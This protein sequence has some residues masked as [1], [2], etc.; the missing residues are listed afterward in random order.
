MFKKQE[1]NILKILAANTK[2]FTEQMKVVNEKV[3]DIE[4]SIEF[5]HNETKKEMNWIRDQHRKEIDELRGK[6]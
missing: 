4:K 3:Q 2:M 1:E 6:G 5:T